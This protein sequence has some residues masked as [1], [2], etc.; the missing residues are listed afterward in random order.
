MSKLSFLPFGVA[1]LTSPARIH[2]KKPPPRNGNGSIAQ[3]APIYKTVSPGPSIYGDTALKIASICSLTKTPIVHHTGR[4]VILL[5]TDG[6]QIRLLGP[7]PFLLSAV[8]GD[9]L[10]FIRSLTD[11]RQHGRIGP[12]SEIDSAFPSPGPSDLRFNSRVKFAV[13]RCSV[14]W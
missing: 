6:I 12:P 4:A 11:R 5:D 9:F 1:C 7:D 13:D 3:V 8:Q 2:L 14:A 10:E